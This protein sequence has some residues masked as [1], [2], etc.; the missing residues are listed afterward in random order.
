M[1]YSAAPLAEKLYPVVGKSGNVIVSQEQ[2]DAIK[3]NWRDACDRAREEYVDIYK[4]H[5]KSCKRK[6]DPHEPVLS[7]LKLGNPLIAFQMLCFGRQHEP[8][9]PLSYGHACLVRDQVLVGALTQCGFRGETLSMMN[10][11][12]LEYDEMR[13]VWLLNV[14]RTLFK[15]ERGPY[16]ASPKGEMRSSRRLRTYPAGPC[17]LAGSP[18]R[19]KTARYRSEAAPP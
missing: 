19:N 16:F 10:L 9:E 15:N 11:D 1:L 18:S 6:R 13:K 3:V 7:I 5:R 14:P 4:S 8:V 2:I 12:H 17:R